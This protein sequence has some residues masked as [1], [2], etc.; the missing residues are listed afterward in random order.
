MV[1]YEAK[2]IPSSISVLDGTGLAKFGIRTY[3]FNKR[4]KMSQDSANK[5]SLSH[6]MSVPHDEGYKVEHSI[7]IERTPHDL[8]H[9]WRNFENLP[10][11][12]KHVKA[13]TVSDNTHSHWIVKGPA[14]KDVEWDAEIINEIADKL[15][16]WRSLDGADVPNAGSVHFEQAASG[17][18]VRVVLKYAPPAGALGA[19]VATLFGENP[20]QQLE[21]DL[22]RFKEVMETNTVSGGKK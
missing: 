21:D 15:I 6:Q 2:E 20:A 14:G 18:E 8:Y 12:M 11:F 16:G 13:V 9:F 19:L 4:H 17:T 3:Q 7:V 1:L 5:D 22:K 10:R